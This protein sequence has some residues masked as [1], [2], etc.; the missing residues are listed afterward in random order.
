[1]KISKR[2]I[3][4]IMA[5]KFASVSE[6]AKLSGV[7]RQNISTVVRRGTCRPLTAAKLA[8]ALGVDPADIIEEED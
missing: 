5:Q 3:E 8:R 6:L 4:L 1:M 2:K 7:S